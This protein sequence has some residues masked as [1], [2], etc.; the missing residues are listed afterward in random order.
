MRRANEPIVPCLTGVSHRA[1]WTDR[2]QIPA[3]GLTAAVKAGSYRSPRSTSTERLEKSFG[4][5]GTTLEEHLRK[6][7]SKVPRAS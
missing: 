4:I 1:T 5:P 7:E 3:P 2:F 6:T